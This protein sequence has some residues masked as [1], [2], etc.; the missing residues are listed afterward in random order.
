VGSEAEEETSQRQGDYEAEYTSSWAVVIGI[1][2]Y[3]HTRKLNYAVEDAVG[4]AEVLVSRLGFAPQNVLAVLDPAPATE[5]TPYRLVSSDATKEAIEELLLTDLPGRAGKDDRVLIFY[6]GHGESRTL[7]DG[8]ARGYLVPA[9]ARPGQWHTCIDLEGVIGAGEFL[10]AKHVF[11]LLDACYSGLATRDIVTPTPYEATMLTHKARQVLTAGNAEQVVADR[12]PDGHS[13][14]TSY[15]LEGLRGE[16]AQES[17][18]IVTASNL[19]VYVKDMVGMTHGSQQTPD[20]GALLGHQSGGDFVFRLPQL[21]FTPEDHVSLGGLLY[22][23][24]Q[25]LD[26]AGRYSSAIHH[27][28]EALAATDLAEDQAA[29]A[30]TWLG[31]ARLVTGDAEG[32]VQALKPLVKQDNAPAEALMYLGVAYARQGAYGQAGKAL[33][34]F[35]TQNPDDENTP[36][37]GAYLNGPKNRFRDKCY[38]RLIGINQYQALRE[39]GGCVND[40]TLMRDLLTIKGSFRRENIQSLLDTHGTRETVLA[41]LQE[42]QRVG[43]SDV[44]IVY[45][46]GHSVPEVARSTWGI[47]NDKDVYLVLHDTVNEALDIKKGGEVSNSISARELHSLMNAIP[48]VHKTLI[49]DTHPSFEL[50]ELCEQEGKY[51]LLLASDSAEVTVELTHNIGGRPTR[52][53]LFTF[54]LVDKLRSAAPQTATFG[55]LVGATI[56]RIRELG[57]DQT[58]VFVGD[59]SDGLFFRELYLGLFDFAQRRTCPAITLDGVRRRYRRVRE[60]VPV[61]HPQAYSSFGRAFLNKGDWRAATEALQMSLQQGS[62]EDPDTL[63]A[64]VRVQLEAGRYADAL[65]SLQRYV[66]SPEMAGSAEEIDALLSSLGACVAPRRHALLVGISQ[67]ANHRIPGVP[68]AASDV[69]SV[70]DILQ[71]RLGYSEDD[72]TTLADGDASRTRIMEHFRHLA[73]VAQE[74]PALFYFAGRGS[75]TAEGNRSLI[76]TDGRESGVEDIDLKELA[77]IVGDKDT[78]LVC[79]IDAGSESTDITDQ[80]IRYLPPAPGSLPSS[81]VETPDLGKAQRPLGVGLVTVYPQSARDETGRRGEAYGQ[82][83]TSLMG[84]LQRVDPDSLTYQ[85]WLKKSYP[86][87]SKLRPKLVGDGRDEMVFGNAVRKNEALNAITRIEQM[88]IRQAIELLNQLV[89]SHERTGQSA[90]EALLDLGVAYAVVGEREL[91]IRTLDR[92]VD[93]Y[94]DVS[95]PEDQPGKDTDAARRRAET[96]YQLGRILYESFESESDLNR[97]ISHLSQATN[98]DPDNIRAFYYH[99]Q[100]LHTLVERTTLAD[101]HK[102]LLTYLARGAPLGHEDEVRSI[103]GARQK[104]TDSEKEADSVW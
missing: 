58:P 103:L 2:N 27:L 90:P 102:A 5:N 79:V 26:D 3:Q 64:L 55:D 29:Q 20:Y 50:I 35:M 39:L 99:G 11:Y 32:A 68:G 13:P 86:D 96:H 98:Q 100:A 52:Y 31:K 37:I 48:A 93:L 85:D 88:P 62:G 71:N 47:T 70:K 46:S 34:A 78:N 72:I 92:A 42:L 12:G 54:V 15:V 6:A 18:E 24:G 8:E 65:D 53:G 14:F 57:Y 44:V 40:V 91:S 17:S 23:V 21:T 25:R 51:S 16:A 69:H 61:A 80:S 4:I 67:Y 60:Q 10:E 82:M 104:P 28:E 59:R 87:R 1:N 9:N 36:W 83:T 73:E 49:L 89:T 30:R 56:A 45:Y 77:E 101:A 41:A 74:E 97:A 33:E 94:D 22:D 95:I 75:I 19:M 84:V 81:S 38:A 66:G 76:S 63:L 43:P 7:P